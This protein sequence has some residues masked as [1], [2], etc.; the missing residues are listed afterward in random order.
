LPPHFT[1][2]GSVAPGI[3]ADAI[4]DILLRVI[5]GSSPSERIGQIEV[6]GGLAT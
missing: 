5:S 6:K 3:G 4:K 2:A 1:A